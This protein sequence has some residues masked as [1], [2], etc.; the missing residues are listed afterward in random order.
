[1]NDRFVSFLLFS[2]WASAIVALMYHLRFFLFVDY[3]AVSQKTSVSQAFYF[4]TGLGHESFAVFVVVDGVASGIIMLHHRF[5]GLFDRTAFFLHIGTVYRVVL[6]G[7]ILGAVFDF[8]GSQYL[9]E[10]GLYTAF[11]KVS[12]LNLS[13][14]SLLGN[15]IMMQPFFVPNFGGNSML[16]LLAYLFWYFVLLLLFIG[17][18]RLPGP[19]RLSAQVGLAAVIVL[20]MPFQFLIWGGIW[21]SG[22]LVVVLGESAVFKPRILLAGALFISALILSR[23]IGPNSS[24]IPIPLSGWVIECKYLVVGIS[25]AALARALYPAKK[26]RQDVSLA[27]ALIGGDE[28]R[29]GLT[30]TFIFFYHFPVIMLLI[31]TGTALLGR[32]LMQQPSLT[33]YA[34]FGLLV[35]LS[36][37]TAALTTRAAAAAI[38]TLGRKR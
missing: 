10:S 31:A 34:E 17:T 25:F 9:N 6:P 8:A 12:T 26:A 20:I 15:L 37:C 23:L 18:R 33:R 4:L 11:P 1:M 14:S 21:L 38:R 35:V 32:P 7:L 27:R 36:L 16:Y 5:R 29:A 24:L 28:G 13:Y 2:R 19:L 22:V 30:A 3:G